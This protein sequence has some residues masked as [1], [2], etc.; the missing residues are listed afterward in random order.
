MLLFLDSS[1]FS[2]QSLQWI[3]RSEKWK[4][5]RK[6]FYWASGK[7]RRSFSSQHH[8]SIHRVIKISFLAAGI[9]FFDVPSS[10]FINFHQPKTRCS[11]PITIHDS[12]LSSSSSYSCFLLHLISLESV[13]M[14]QKANEKNCI[15][16]TL[17]DDRK[18]SI[19]HK[20]MEKEKKFF[21]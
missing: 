14:I 20:L 9:F 10:I 4:G 19:W 21:F 7:E 1:I 11:N 15:V 3:K 5:E 2:L 6:L 18:K 17:Y 12:F 8:F 13:K 16:H